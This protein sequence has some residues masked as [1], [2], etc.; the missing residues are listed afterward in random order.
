MYLF[1]GLGN[2]GEAYAYTRHNV[3]RRAVSF[4]VAAQGGVWRVSKKN[5]GKVWE[6]VIVDKEVHALLPETF[7]NHSG[8]SVKTIIK[9]KKQAEH[10]V[11]VYDDIDLPLG[12]VRISFDRG[13]GGHNGIKSIVASLNTE[14]FVRVRIGIS[15]SVSGQIKKPKTADAVLKW[16]LGDFK[17]AEEQKLEALFEKTREIFEHILTKGVTSAMNAYN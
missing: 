17:K 8:D 4:F 6:G 2:T 13:S 3:G 12:V 10:L 7:M 14:A 15:P 16:V 5:M 11:V 9:T 1:V